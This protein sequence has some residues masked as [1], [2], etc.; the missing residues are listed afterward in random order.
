MRK[1]VS[2]GIAAAMTVLAIA[3]VGPALPASAAP[4]V[5]GSPTVGYPPKASS[6]AQLAASTNFA[7]VGDKLELSGTH[8]LPNEDVA[9]YI[10]GKLTECKPST[11]HNFI[12]V[13]TAHTDANGSFDPTVTVPNV[14]GHVTMFGI[15]ASLKGYDYSTQPL[16]IAATNNSSGSTQPPAHTGVDIAL[17]LAAGGLLVGAGVVFTRGGKRRRVASHS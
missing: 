6:S 16:T 13:G 5:C 14:S 12:K 3:V 9:L 4:A 1:S 2:A 17:M 15:G 8:Y 10:S 11:L 7:H